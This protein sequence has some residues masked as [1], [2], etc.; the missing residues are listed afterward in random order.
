MGHCYLMGIEFS[1]ATWKSSGDLFHNKSEYT[2]QYWAVHLEVVNFLS[3]VFTTI[4][5]MKKN[6]NGKSETW[7]FKNKKRLPLNC[8]NIDLL[9]FHIPERMNSKEV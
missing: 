8:G 5:E 1:F 6:R 3:Y 2:Y 9:T 4:K 7:V